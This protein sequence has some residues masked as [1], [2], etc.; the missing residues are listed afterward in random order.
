MGDQSDSVERASR[1]LKIA[2]AEMASFEERIA[3][4]PSL[5]AGGKLIEALSLALHQAGIGMGDLGSFIEGSERT[6]FFLGLPLEGSV[7]TFGKECRIF[8]SEVAVL[9]RHVV[10]WCKRANPREALE[11]P[12]PSALLRAFLTVSEGLGRLS[13]RVG[14]LVPDS[15]EG[16]LEADQVRRRIE[17]ANESMA[18][19]QESALALREELHLFHIKVMSASSGSNPSGR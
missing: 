4:D 13:F 19:F 6:K 15:P 3:S 18:R 12:F 8:A 17:G 5:A 10:D 11:Q 16:R 9:R 7:L 14:N 2:S 1:S